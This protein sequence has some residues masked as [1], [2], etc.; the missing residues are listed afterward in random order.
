MVDGPDTP[1]A[2]AAPQRVADL[3]RT[4]APS[5]DQRRRRA[6]RPDAPRTIVPL[7]VVPAEGSTPL[8]PERIDDARRRLKEQAA[9][10]AA[11]PPVTEAVPVDPDAFDSARRRLRSTRSPRSAPPRG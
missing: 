6:R 1:A 9:A 11:A 7:L 4:F 2:G 8:D 10:A 5:P 3:L